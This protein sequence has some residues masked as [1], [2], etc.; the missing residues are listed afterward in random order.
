[1]SSDLL[2]AVKL[3]GLILSLGLDTLAVS[4]ALGIGGAGCERR[5][6]IGLSFALFEGLMPLVGFLAGHAISKVLG[7]AAALIGIVMLLAIGGW[8]LYETIFDHEGL[9]AA[10]PRSRHTITSWHGLALT[11]LSI[12]L[13][14]LAVGFSLG[15]L[16]LPVLL[17]TI[18]IAAQAFVFSFIGTTLGSRIGAQLAERAEFGAGLMLVTIALLLLIEHGIEGGYHVH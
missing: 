9:G 14:E 6:R 12:S 16:A 13:D 8:M 17:A 15:L 4:I 2:T 7:V 1:V 11:S 3:A 10:A 18:L 5:W